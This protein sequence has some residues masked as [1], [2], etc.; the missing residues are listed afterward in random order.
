MRPSRRETLALLA[1]AS[2][3][4]NAPVTFAQIAH[5]QA[6]TQAIKPDDQTIADA[7]I[8]LLGRA[9]VI[10]QEHTDRKEPGF[11]Y[12]KIKYNLG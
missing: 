9:L 12:N 7:Y 3:A 8:Y 1:T 5:A 6:A 2:A 4:L 11:A 10:R